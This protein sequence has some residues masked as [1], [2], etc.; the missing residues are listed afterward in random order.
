MKQ[1][2][3]KSSALLLCEP[4]QQELLDAFYFNSF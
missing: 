3:L 1:T 2:P 4:K